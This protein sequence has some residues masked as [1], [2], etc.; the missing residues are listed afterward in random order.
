[1]KRILALIVLLTPLVVRAEP[2]C[3]SGSID[4]TQQIAEDD[5]TLEN[6]QTAL[7]HLKRTLPALIK[8]NDEQFSER[9]LSGRPLRKLDVMMS[10][11]LL[12]PRFKQ[13][14]ANNLAIVEGFILR[15]QLDINKQRFMLS[16]NDGNK[17]A[18]EKALGVFCRHVE[19]ARYIE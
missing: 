5:F 6:A 13:Y 9:I 8:Q 17:A 1:M 19:A 4:N 14:H 18:Y 11:I 3:Q 16:N 12:N 15:Q 2:L 7:N 10:S